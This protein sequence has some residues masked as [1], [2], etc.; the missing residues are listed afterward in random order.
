MYV[1]LRLGHERRYILRDRRPGTIACPGCWA[2]RTNKVKKC[3]TEKEI[4]CTG[5]I[6]AAKSGQNSLV[7]ARQNQWTNQ[8]GVAPAECWNWGKYGLTNKRGP[9][10]ISSLDSSYWS[11]GFFPALAALG[12]QVQNIFPHCLLFQFIC[13]HRPASWADSCAGSPVS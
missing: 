12:A 11:K 8:R 6:R 3:A 9:S 7:L 5:L 4:F 10:L 1:S 13:P 2:M